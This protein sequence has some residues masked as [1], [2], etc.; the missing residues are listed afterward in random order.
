[1]Q[2]W[3]YGVAA[4]IQVLK[5]Y[6]RVRSSSP[7]AWSDWD[8]DSVATTIT[9]GQS[10]GVIDRS[11]PTPCDSRDSSPVGVD[12]EELQVKLEVSQDELEALDQDTVNNDPMETFQETQDLCQQLSS[13]KKQVKCAEKAAKIKHLRS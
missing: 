1:M 9:Q 2:L 3:P 12:S 6:V 10:P 13:K 11:Q 4:P 5:K 8:N 7:L